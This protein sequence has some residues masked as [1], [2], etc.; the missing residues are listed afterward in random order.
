MHPSDETEAEQ[1]AWLRELKRLVPDPAVSNLIFWPNHHK[2]AK[3]LQESELMPEK[4]VELAFS[5]EPFAL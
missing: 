2:L 3:D 1:D 4:I 5:Y